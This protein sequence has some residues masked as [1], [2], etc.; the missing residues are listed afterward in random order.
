MNFFKRAWLYLTAKVG[1]TAI[2]M[3]VFTAIKVFVLAG[4]TIR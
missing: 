1:K 4:L 3:L 2:L